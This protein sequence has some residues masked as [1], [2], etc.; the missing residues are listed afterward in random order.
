MK[1]S[2]ITPIDIKYSYRGTEY[3]VYEA[4]RYLL[5]RGIDAE[6]L[7][8]ET[9][10]RKILNPKAANE[11]AEVPGRIIKSSRLNLPMNF[12]ITTYEDL[13][14]DSILYFPYSIYDYAINIARKPSGQKWIIGS[15]SMH[16]KHGHI[17][18]GHQWLELALN[19]IMKNVIRKNNLFYHVVNIDQERYLIGLGIEK[20]RVF[21]IPPFIDVQGFKSKPATGK[22][23]KVMH[24][25]GIE[26]NAETVSRIIACLIELGQIDR[27]E[28]YLIGKQPESI[29]QYSKRLKHGNISIFPSISE[30]EK[31]AMMSN[32][33]V[34]LLPA[35]ENFS[36]SM[37]EGM[38]SGL[39]II[40]GEMDP[41]FSELLERKAFGISSKNEGE[42]ISS[43]QLAL[44]MK[45]DG[46]LGKYKRLNVKAAGFYDRKVVL[47]L[48]EKM[49]REVDDFSEK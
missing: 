7:I 8:T 19:A 15:H 18:K 30:V 36:K 35:V 38:A 33:D 5:R 37:I 1:A 39:Y 40:S 4:T 20:G 22:K 17:I 46:K 12:K 47:P 43:L 25:G 34:M 3:W 24:L 23:L 11:F 6:V 49:F 2:L 41:A 26:K 14:K 44:E 45:L 29:M 16:L 42:Y 32:M 27:F 10:S 21:R 28:F 13:P 48:I 31:R 9:V